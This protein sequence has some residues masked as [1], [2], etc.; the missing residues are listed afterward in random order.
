MKT[1]LSLISFLIIFT[2]CQ[3]NS[4]QSE[5]VGVAVDSTK[6]T[7][8]IGKQ[9]KIDANTE[10]DSLKFPNFKMNIQEQEIKITPEFQNEIA[11]IAKD[12]IKKQCEQDTLY[13]DE[14]YLKDRKHYRSS[15]GYDLFSFAY[16]FKNSETGMEKE[17]ASFFVFGIKQNGKTIFYDIA[18]DLIGEIQ[19]KLSGF[20]ITENI[21][22]VWGEMYPY[23]SSDDYGKFKLT[24]VGQETTYEFQ[25]KSQGH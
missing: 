6:T 7:E 3:T 21:T 10:C 17:S 23:F 11:K 25:C 14:I 5:Q 24:I 19:L 1:T 22:I 18:A 20:E 15:L 8:H 4:G 13:C 2:A 16:A 9:E 12:F